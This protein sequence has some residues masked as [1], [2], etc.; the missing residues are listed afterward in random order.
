MNKI[1]SKTICLNMIV[2]NESHIIVKTLEN[3]CSNINFAYWVIVD[4]GSTDNTC[5][6]ITDFFKQKDIPGE[7]HSTEWKDFA[8]NRT[9]ALNK[10]YNKTDY[11]LIFEADDSIEGN[12]ILPELTCDLYYLISGTTF[13]YKRA[14]LISNRIKS[15]FKGVLHEYVTFINHTHQTIG[16]IEGDYNI[17]PGHGGSRSLDPNK[18]LNDALILKDA[19]NNETDIKLKTRYAFYCAQSYMDYGMF[20]DAIEWYKIRASMGGWLQEVYYSYYKIGN[21]YNNMNEKE[22]AIYYWIESFT[23]DNERIEGIYEVIKHYREKSKYNIAYQYYTMIDTTKDITINDKIFVSTDIYKYKIY[24]EF[25]IIAAYVNKHKDAINSFKKLMSVKFD[26]NYSIT[27]LN[28]F[29]FYKSYVNSDDIEFYH[30][31][32]NY[33][34]ILDIK[35]NE[36]QIKTINYIVELFT[37]HTSVFDSNLYKNIAT[38]LHV[39]NKNI[40]IVNLLKRCDRKKSMIEQL[41]KYNINN[42]TFIEA[43]DG[44]NIELDAKIIR[45]FSGNYFNNRKGVIGCALSHL[46][47]WI[48][49]LLSDDMYCI[50]FEDDIDINLLY[51]NPKEEIDKA[52]KYLETNNNIDLLLLGYHMKSEYE[53]ERYINNTH[54]MGQFDKT[55]YVGGTFAYII[56]KK[57]AKKLVDYIMINGIKNPIDDMMILTVPDIC[58]HYIQPHLVLSDWVKTNDS[59]VDT[60]IQN[61]WIRFD[62]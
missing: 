23:I 14:L 55:K 57:C 7:L 47:I 43:V 20:N 6:L 27:T 34:K 13:V 38:Q 19:Y 58:I 53:H 3:L 62:F 37:P 35:F 52:I 31:F 1:F 59:K 2:K 30:I 54:D 39:I 46:N 26:F 5:E 33:I 18:Y 10:A 61:N 24:F 60:D 42:Y 50:V 8:Y 56:T 22:K 29:A 25:T 16:I 21:M 32:M 15:E 40:I 11:L 48:S 44:Y 36:Q 28:N 12:I 4:T 51:N 41:D 45:L 49:L 17:V 9:D